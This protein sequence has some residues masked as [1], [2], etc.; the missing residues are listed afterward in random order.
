M[1]AGFRISCKYSICISRICG[2][3]KAPLLS[4]AGSDALH[5]RGASL[6]LRRHRGLRGQIILRQDR[7]KR[8]K[9]P[10]AKPGALELGPPKAVIGIGGRLTT[11]PLPHWHTGDVPRRFD[12]VE[13]QHVQP[14]FRVLSPPRPVRPFGR[15]PFTR[16]QSYLPLPIVRAFVRRFRRGLSVAPPFGLECLTSLADSTAYYALF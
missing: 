9:Y 3:V 15:S 6:S 1:R 2:P 7:A 4:P 8:S 13:L 16:C 10:P 14:G 5:N 11:P 12:R